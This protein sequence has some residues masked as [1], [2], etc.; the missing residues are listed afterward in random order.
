MKIGICDDLAEEREHIKKYCENLGYTDISLYSSGEELLESPELESLNLLFLDIELN[1]I[2]GIRIK[3]TL[4]FSNPSI[5]VVF[6]TAHHELMPDAFGRNVI[7]FL[8]KPYSESSIADCIKKVTYFN[9]QFYPITIEKEITI[10]CKDILYV[11]TE[12]KYSIFY[13]T[14]KKSYSSR[15]PLKEW[16]DILEE[17]G[18]CR[19]SRSTIINFKYCKQIEENHVFLFEDISLPVSRRY[20]QSLRKKYINYILHKM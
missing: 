6:S 9:R 8:K 17:F 12:Q 4:E 3:N 13:T 20:L 14:D 10:P 1:G 2:D 18:F 16:V 11:H 5:F 15:K 7:S 19:I